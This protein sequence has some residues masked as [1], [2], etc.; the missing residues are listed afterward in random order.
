MNSL[1]LTGAAFSNSTIDFPSAPPPQSVRS[2]PL[3]DRRAK[4][5]RAQTS[6]SKICET[7]TEPNDSIAAALPPTRSAPQ[8]E[9]RNLPTGAKNF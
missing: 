5:I 9:I 7:K 1:E 2:S 3:A 8:V 6:H 4:L